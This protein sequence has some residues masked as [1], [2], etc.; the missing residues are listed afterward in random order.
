MKMLIGGG[1]VTRRQLRHGVIYTV[2][3]GGAASTPVILTSD[4]LTGD[5]MTPDILA[6]T[7]VILAPKAPQSTNRRK[8][9]SS[10]PSAGADQ[11]EWDALPA[12]PVGASDG[13]WADYAE[14]RREMAKTD[15]RQRSQWTPTVARKAI[16]KLHALAAEGSDPGAVLDQSVLN[17][18]Q[19]LFPVKDDRHG[20][21]NQPGR[22]GASGAGGYRG[23]PVDGFAA[24]LNIVASG[25]RADHDGRG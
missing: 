17:T 11:A 7:P 21:R 1:H 5:N 12:L 6:A 14:M 3:P 10:S 9:T 13:Q 25:G 20:E 2:H 4:N 19:G 18:W 15:R 8:K 23:R 24:A 16:Q 22:G